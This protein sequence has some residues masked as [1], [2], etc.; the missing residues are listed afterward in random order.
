[1]MLYGSG[2]KRRLRK[3]YVIR[4]L[5][6]QY[7]DGLLK[8]YIPLFTCHINQFAEVCADMKY[9]QVNDKWLP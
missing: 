9:I 8:K 5:E 7:D 6:I 3:I 2:K 4:L 1:M